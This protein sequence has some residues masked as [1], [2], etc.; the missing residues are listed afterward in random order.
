[1]NQ[2]DQIQKLNTSYFSFKWIYN[3]NGQ[4]K[5]LLTWPFF[6][7]P[8][9]GRSNQTSDHEYIIKSLNLVGIVTLKTQ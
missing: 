9:Q 4:Y 8:H 2:V 6:Q 5:T 1:M 3:I 7:F